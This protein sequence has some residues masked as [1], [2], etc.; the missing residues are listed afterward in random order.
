[1]GAGTRERPKKRPDAA[2]PCTSS[3]PYGE[4]CAPFH[5]GRRLAATCLELARSR[6]SA[7]AL[8]EIDYLVR[9][10]HPDHPDRSLPPELMRSSIREACRKYKYTG[11]T[12]HQHEE[13]GDRGRVSFLA[14]VFANG[15]DLSFEEDSLF[16]RTAD[17]WGYL[18]GETIKTRAPC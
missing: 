3:R 10:L 14:K 6:Y 16:Q 8:A 7:F 13:T 18:S 15:K 4:C 11:L 9:S 5:K 2:C 1:M 17:G 12:V